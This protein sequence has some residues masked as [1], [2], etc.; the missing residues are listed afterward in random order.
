MKEDLV[1]NHEQYLSWLKREYQAKKKLDEDFE[2]FRA[3]V[4]EAH[5]KY[6]AERYRIWIEMKEKLERSKNV[7]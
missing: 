3:R 4:E 5:N 1:N 7:S 6:K 2:S